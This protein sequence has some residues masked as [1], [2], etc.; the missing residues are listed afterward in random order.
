[1]NTSRC[2]VCGAT[3]GMTTKTMHCVTCHATFTTP[4]NCDRHQRGTKAD[5]AWRC[6]PPS[7]VGLVE[8]ANSFGTPVWRSP[9]PTDEG[10]EDDA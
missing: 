1:M 5:P 2:R 9:G 10:G 7:S 8:K 4:N 6:R 3:W